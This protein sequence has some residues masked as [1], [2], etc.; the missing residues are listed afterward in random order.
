M[1]KGE[2]DLV[3]RL[4]QAEDVP[5]MREI[6]VKAW[7]PIYSGYCERMGDELYRLEGH[8]DWQTKKADDVSSFYDKR[9]DWCLVAEL[10]G[11]V[12]GFTTFVLH[13]EYHIGEIGNNAVH[14]D[15]QDQGIGCA[16]CQRV[17][18]IFRQEGMKYAK[19]HT[20]LDPAHGPARA[21]YEKV[22]FKQITPQATYYRKLQI[23]S[24]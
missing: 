2:S 12:V 13:R 10:R 4:A 20:G 5:R 18:E 24:T 17:L 3:I 19:V 15:Y 21:M 14:P 23:H 8:S 9:P 22:G 1:T 16:Q 11:Q 6:A 7:R